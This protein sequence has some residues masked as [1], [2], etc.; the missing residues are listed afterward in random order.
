MLPVLN[1][2]NVQICAVM[3][4]KKTSLVLQYVCFGV[5]KNTNQTV[6]KFPN[7]NFYFSKQRLHQMLLLLIATDIKL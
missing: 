3:F 7:T 5:T 2:V 4:G 6:E 1:R